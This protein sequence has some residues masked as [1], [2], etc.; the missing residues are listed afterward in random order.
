MR[1]I[2]RLVSPLG[3]VA[4]LV[5]LGLSL[6]RQV[7]V[8]SQP[9]QE[10]KPGSERRTVFASAAEDLARLFSKKRYVY[11]ALDRKD[12]FLSPLE[13]AAG[14]GEGIDLMDA[15]GAKLVGIA[16]SGGVRMAMF[17]DSEGKGYVLRVGDRVQDGKVS[18]ITARTVK[19]VRNVYG[20]IQRL[21]FKMQPKGGEHGNP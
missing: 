9:R 18:R 8:R 10:K 12:P 4:S 20:E 17:E 13:G 1:R 5:V 11:K 6:D 2:L 19:I 21:N 3:L 15:E 7:E 14:S 16:R